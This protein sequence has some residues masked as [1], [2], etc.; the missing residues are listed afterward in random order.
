M[1]SP[2]VA[3]HSQTKLAAVCSVT[4]MAGTLRKPERRI[5]TTF[6]I[7]DR[8]LLTHWDALSVV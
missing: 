5:S 7:S 6:K 2:L 4:K 8:Q 1:H 3:N